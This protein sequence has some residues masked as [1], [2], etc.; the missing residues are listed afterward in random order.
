MCQMSQSHVAG[1]IIVSS[2]SAPGSEVQRFPF[3]KYCI[4]SSI[5]EELFPFILIYYFEMIRNPSP[6]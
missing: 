2:R 3:L 6:V 4:S 1:D 5:L